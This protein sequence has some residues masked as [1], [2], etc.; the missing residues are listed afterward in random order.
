MTGVVVPED[1]NRLVGGRYR[2]LAVIGRGGMSTVWLA[3]DETL[4]KQW[5]VKEIRLSATP[6][7]RAIVVDSLTREAN[8]IKRLDHPAIPRIVD[9]LD[10]EGT[11]YVVMDY[12]EGR[13]LSSVVAESGPQDEEDVADWAT[14]LCDVLDYLHQREPSLVYLDMKPSNV[15]L[16]PDGTVRLIDF[17]ITREEG[18][19][20]A[21]EASL[22]TPGYAAPEQ[23]QRG[24]SIDRRADV[25][26]L[27]MTMRALLL[28][29][30]TIAGDDLTSVR[31]V[32]PEVS[33]GMDAVISRATNRD[34]EARYSG[35]AELAYA[36]AEERAHDEGHYRRLRRRWRAFVGTCVAAVLCL[37]V[38]AG[39]HVA[40]E[41][42]LQSDFDYWMQVAEQATD[43][44]QTT[45]A[46]LRAI[47]A[48]PGDTEPYLGLVALYREDGSFSA[49]EEHQLQSAIAPHLAELESDEEAWAGLSFEVGK[50]YW[51][52]YETDASVLAANNVARAVGSDTATV[53]QRYARIRASERWMRE[54]AQVDGFAQSELAGCYATIA[55]FNADIVPLINEGSDEGAYAPYFE[56]LMALV[57]IL[58]ESGNDVTRLEVANLVL[59]SLRTYPRKFRADGVSREDMLAAVDAAEALALQTSPTTERQ[60]ELWERAMGSVDAARQSVEESF[61]DV[62]RME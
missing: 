44:E 13:P 30:R 57:D 16:R 49:E 54:A 48:R 2:L 46:Y 40:R 50:L 21:G 15:M 22:G 10:E 28:G 36:I 19:L 60:D 12:V 42:M 37:S 20:H 6:E 56:Q 7:E 41:V 62:G 39:T 4:G 32:R 18:P 34:P 14:Q 25:Y 11:L 35:A 51:Y 29:E 27:G 52:F 9:L 58:A 5:A 8:L 26:S 38:S 53:S 1:K 55:G 24:A 47:E 23:C 61:V 45:E 3:M 33:R 31:Q 43:A 17:G 59:D